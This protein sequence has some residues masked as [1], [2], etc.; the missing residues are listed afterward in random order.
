MSECV[1]CEI[2][3]GRVKAH[4]INEDDLVVAFL[5]THPIRPGHVQ[6]I[7]RNHFAYFDDLPP[8]TAARVV[9]VGQRV[10]KALKRLSGV[11]RVAFLFTGGD[12]AHAHAHLVPMHEKTDITSRRYI[13]EERLT[14]RSTPEALEGELAEVAT[15]LRRLSDEVSGVD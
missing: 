14:F 4:L 15:R 7:P 12:V 9:L 1:F 6:I 11:P 8:E 10:A 5:D 13:A 3:K 2:A